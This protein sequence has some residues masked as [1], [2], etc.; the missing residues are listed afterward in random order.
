[1]AFIGPVAWTKSPRAESLMTR[2][3]RGTGRASG[4]AA[5]GEI[6]QVLQR[7]APGV[8]GHAGERRLGLVGELVGQVQGRF[9]GAGAGD[10]VAGAAEVL[11]GLL[12]TTDGPLPETGLARAG[13]G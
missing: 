10:Q 2:I 9:G 1:M 3:R 11:V 12:A 6:G 8:V 4:A 5:D 7:R 13:A